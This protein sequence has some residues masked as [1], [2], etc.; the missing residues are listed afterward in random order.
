MLACTVL[1]TVVVIAEGAA[2]S[3]SSGSCWARG[4]LTTACAPSRK[5]A[6]DDLW[7]DSDEDDDTSSA[8]ESSPRLS[9]AP[10]EPGRTLAVLPLNS[11]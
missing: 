3:E 2:L 4:T 8:G 7:G 1:C 11:A 10:R 5:V 9:L 6:G